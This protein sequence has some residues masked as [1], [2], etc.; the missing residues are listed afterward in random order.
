MP[1]K[2]SRKNGRMEESRGYGQPTRHNP[3]LGIMTIMPSSA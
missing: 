3:E 1:S 2:A